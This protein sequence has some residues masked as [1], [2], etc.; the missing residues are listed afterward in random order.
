MENS[1]IFISEHNNHTIGGTVTFQ[2]NLLRSI[3][4]LARHIIFI[5]PSDIQEHSRGEDK[6]EYF[7]IKIPNFINGKDT[8]FNRNQRLLFV[9]KVNALLRELPIHVHTIVHILFGWYLFDK[10]DY[11]YIHQQGAKITSTIH[12]IPP[13]ECGIT[14]FGDNSLNYIKGNIKNFLLRLITIKRF[15]QSKCDCIFVP[16]AP[17]N[18]HISQILKFCNKSTKVATIQHGVTSSFTSSSNKSDKLVLLTVGGI[19]PSKRQLLIPKIAKKLQD[20]NITYEWNIIGPIRNQRYYNA[21]AQSIKKHNLSDSVFIHSYLPEKNLYGIYSNSTIY[22]HT[23]KEE[24]FCFTGIDAVLH[25]L[26]IIAVQETGELPTLIDK[27]YGII[28]S[29]STQSF[30]NAILNVLNTP[31][32]INK[33]NE[34][35]FLKF[36]SWEEAAQKYICEFN[37]L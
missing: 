11:H 4:K 28:V 5:Y 30:V 29:G 19:A 13:Q 6:I 18:R 10:I 25:Y 9:E 14:W 8:Q 22:I 21:I 7:G 33:I 32:K 31:K 1:L 34:K 16:S 2:I 36:Y 35:E 26:P 15:Y 3:S 20:L 24:G 27:S 17:V 23:G 37:Q 12:N